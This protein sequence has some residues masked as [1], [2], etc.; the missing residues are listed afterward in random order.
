VNF[1]VIPSPLGV[2]ALISAEEAMGTEKKW[3]Q[4]PFSVVMSSS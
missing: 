3:G 1:R 4:A 2:K